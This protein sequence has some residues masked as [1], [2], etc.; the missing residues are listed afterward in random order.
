LPNFVALVDNYSSFSI[1]INQS[2]KNRTNNVQTQNKPPTLF[3]EWQRR[4][5]PI[6]A[7]RRIRQ[8]SPAL[9]ALNIVYANGRNRKTAVE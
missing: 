9:A 8:T 6:P 7:N 3:L 4:Q 2:I 1:D 5:A